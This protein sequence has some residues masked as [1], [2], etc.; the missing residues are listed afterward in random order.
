MNKLILLNVMQGVY[1]VYILN[2]F[3]TKYSFAH[4]LSNFSNDYLKHP[5][6][7]NNQ[8]I[9]NICEFGHQVSWFLALFIILRTL[10]KNRFTKHIS[11]I[12]L[13]I[14]ATFSL[15]NFNAVI[16]LLP[17]FAIEIYLIKNNFYL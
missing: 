2:F 17:H 3:K 16:Y 5:I 11:I 14:T 9:S 6:G 12:V 15:L 7:V 13:I 4:P 8:P 1:I 10:F